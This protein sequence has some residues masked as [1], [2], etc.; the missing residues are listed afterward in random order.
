MAE[1]CLVA[2]NTSIPPYFTD[3]K[4]KVSWKIPSETNTYN[5][6]ETEAEESFIRTVIFATL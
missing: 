4:K 6:R 5:D 3:T 1:A 2:E